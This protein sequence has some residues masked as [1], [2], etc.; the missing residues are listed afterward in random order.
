[1]LALETIDLN[2]S[3][4]MY[5][6]SKKLSLH[7][8]FPT[9]VSI[10]KLRCNNP[11][12]KTFVSNNLKY[13]EFDALLKITSEMAKYLYPYIRSILASL[14]NYKSR[15]DLW[16]D[17]ENRLIDLIKQRFNTESI[18]VKKLID[19]EFSKNFYRKILLTLA[20]CQSE[21][22]YDRLKISLFNL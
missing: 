20:M 5:S 14:D 22:G 8:I 6:L 4:S 10:W 1:L 21:D 16:N 9:K 11:L 3:E 15:P 12:R 13:H 2:G 17:F 19:F 18:L 7:E